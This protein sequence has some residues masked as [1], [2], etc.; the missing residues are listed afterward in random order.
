MTNIKNNISKNN[1][2]WIEPHRYMELKHFCLQYP[3]WEKA[4]KSINALQQ[5][6]IC[7]EYTASSGRSVTERAAE[8]LLYYS[9]RME[10]V[11][12]TAK[13]VSTFLYPY[14]LC[15]VTTGVTF[16]QMGASGHIPCS[17]N[18]YYKA[19]REFFFELNKVH[20]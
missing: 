7:A 8:Q 4:Y 18:E 16:E 10:M 14:L 3:I 9:E 6:N 13:L 5:R 1:P 2:Y 19:Y 20:Y 15:G 11:E 17:R 12:K